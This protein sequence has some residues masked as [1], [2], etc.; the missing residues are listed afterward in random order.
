[1]RIIHVV[2]GSWVCSRGGGSVIKSG[3]IWSI[4]TCS[5]ASGGLAGS[6]DG[7]GGG[8]TGWVS[9]TANLVGFA[10][11]STV[12]STN[13]A[14]LNAVFDL[15]SALKVWNGL[16]IFSGVWDCVVGTDA[17]PLKGFGITVVGEPT[18]GLLIEAEKSARRHLVLT[19]YLLGSEADILGVDRI[20]YGLC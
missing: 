11:L 4:G 3:I 9:G 6:L 2:G 16:A 17:V 7:G 19:P 10:S 20:V 14:V 5:S 15:V 8:E 13:S 1:L 18:T 12:L